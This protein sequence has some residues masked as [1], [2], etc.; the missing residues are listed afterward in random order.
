[1]NQRSSL[2]KE[3]EEYAAEFL[4]K[5]K[6]KIIGRNVLKPW[7][8]LD[9]V[10]IAPDKTLVFVEVKTMEDRGEEFLS[11]ENQMSFSKIKKFK[12]AASLY[13]GAHEKLVDKKRGWRLD[14]IALSKW[15]DE[16]DA[17]YYENIE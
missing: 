16:Y 8:E 9:I 12:K 15:A 17:R 3:G 6:Y 11:P 13:A 5:K 10:A 1:M 7:G 2:G 14:V 4:K